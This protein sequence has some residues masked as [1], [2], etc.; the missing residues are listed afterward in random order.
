MKSLRHLRNFPSELAVGAISAFCLTWVFEG[1]DNPEFAEWASALFIAS[2]TIVAA[3]LAVRGVV[4]G[5]E[6][7]REQEER[8]TSASNQAARAVLPLLLMEL[9]KITDEAVEHIILRT[10]EFEAIRKVGIEPRTVLAIRDA[11]EVLTAPEAEALTEVPSIF[12]IL[13]VE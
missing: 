1:S 12:Q 4:A 7:S 2:C 9:R 13:F 11:L 10:G 5:I 6:H 3:A 8:R